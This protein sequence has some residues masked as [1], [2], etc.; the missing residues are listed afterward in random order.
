MYKINP[1]IKW[2]W[3]GDK[4]LLSTFI[5][6]NRI[7]GEVVEL[8]DRGNDPESV[9]EELH[10]RYPDVLY[11]KIRGDICAITDQLIKLNIVVSEKSEEYED[12]PHDPFAMGHIGQYFGN[13]LTAPVGVACEITAR[14]NARCLHCSIPST[15]EATGE[16]TT[17]QWK[18]IIDEMADIKV[19]GAS[20]T[21]GEPLVRKDILD[22]VKYAHEKG[23]RVSVATNGYLLDEL[24][25][26]SLVANGADFFMV[27]LDGATAE[28]HDTFRGL[29]GLFE[30][31]T[32]ALQLLVDKKISVGVIAIV[33]TMNLNEV[34]DLIDVVKDIGVT[35][36]SLANIR[37]AGRAAENRYL[38]PTVEDF[39]KFLSDLYE[40]DQKIA[41]IDVK[42]PNLPAKLYMESI[43]MDSYRNVVEQGKIGVCGAGIIGCAI[44]P[45]GDVKPC[46]MSGP[47]NLGNVLEMSLKEVWDTSK[48]F[49]HLR[50][51]QVETQIPCR[52]C[53]LSHLCL[54]GCRAQPYQ[55]GEGGD[56]LLADTTR[57]QCFD[58]FRDELVKEAG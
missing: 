4:I 24:M 27:S 33:T 36:L 44:S 16:L 5:G 13:K 47:V 11:D 17:D 57:R 26:D 8:Y 6:M 29:P 19:F 52:D 3:E 18:K 21:G 39:M 45:A 20:F 43:G 10:K 38:E 49:E 40:K 54:P 15:T 55:V 30:R 9:I 28:T 2:R 41:G 50:S 48:V 7:A 56:M 25:I 53:Q 35:R 22:L 32:S 51:I 12:V 34:G 23:L 37:L 58:A 31:V 42:Y 46:D 14:C 1:K